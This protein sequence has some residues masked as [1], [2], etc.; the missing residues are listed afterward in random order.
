MS[1]WLTPH[2][3]EDLNY[4]RQ[5]QPA[6]AL[7]VEKLLDR[8]DAGEKLPDLGHTRLEFGLVSLT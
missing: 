1:V 2:A 4:W 6:M 7:R 5:S 8:L 3:R